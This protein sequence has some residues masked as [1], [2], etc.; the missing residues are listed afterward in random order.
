EDTHVRVFSEGLRADADDALRRAQ[1]RDG[2]END[3]PSRNLSRWL[4]TLA[5]QDSGKG[6]AVRQVWRADRMGRGG[7]HLPFED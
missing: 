6:L 2:G 7:D 3:S 1:R 5:A 4:A